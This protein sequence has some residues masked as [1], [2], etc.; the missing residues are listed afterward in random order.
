MIHAFLPTRSNIQV[1]ILGRS[2]RDRI[3]HQAQVIKRYPF[4]RRIVE[5]AELPAGDFKRSQKGSYGY[6]IVSIVRLTHQDGSLSTRSYRSNYYPVPEVIWIGPGTPTTS[7][8][9]LPEGADGIEPEATA[10]P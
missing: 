2:P 8:P 6:D 7:L 10:S 3:E 9:P 4:L 5:K 1:E